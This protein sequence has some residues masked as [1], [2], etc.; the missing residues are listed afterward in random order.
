MTRLR[1]ELYHR[2]TCLPQAG[3]ISLRGE[4]VLDGFS[5]TFD[6]TADVDS[7]VD[8]DLTGDTDS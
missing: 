3:K 1:G 4:I 6:S 2:W 5:L 7:L 8:K